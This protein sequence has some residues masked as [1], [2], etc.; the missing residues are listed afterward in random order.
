MGRSMFL[1]KPAALIGSVFAFVLFGTSYG[2]GESLYSYTDESGVRVLTNIPPK[3]PVQQL[4]TFG[5]PDEPAETPSSSSFDR[6]TA[7]D[8]IIDK[9][10]T[11]YNLDPSLIRSMIATESAFNAKAVSRKGAQGLM[12]L[13]PSTASRL[14]VNNA[15][16]P[17][18]NIKGGV[19]HM[20]YL[21]DTFDN[22]LSLSLAAYNAGE[23]LVQ[24]L[25]RVPNIPETHNYVKT[26]TKLYGKKTL[27]S[28]DTSANSSRSTY[29]YV[30]ENG[31]LHLT[32]IPPAQK[33][34]A[35]ITGWALQNQLL[36]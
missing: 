27:D 32:S 10:A 6:K 28:S 3:S 24:R 36:Q 34:S 29:R 13:M 30:D 20:R 25:G 8:P 5:A 11:Q 2:Y 21:L 31:I 1:L 18:Q 23:N 14:G 33:N 12:Q 22:N 17:E 9:Y 7:Y 16:D 15:F 4:R 19:K 35:G 26:I